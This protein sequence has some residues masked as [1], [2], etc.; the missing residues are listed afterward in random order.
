MVFVSVLMS[1][2]ANTGESSY[3]KQNSTLYFD[4]NLL[5]EES[6]NVARLKNSGTASATTTITAALTN[7][8]ANAAAT[9]GGSTTYTSLV[10]NGMAKF[11]RL[12]QST[13]EKSYIRFESTDTTILSLQANTDSFIYYAWINVMVENTTD[14]TFEIIGTRN[15]SQVGNTDGARLYGIV[16]NE[17]FQL[18]FATINQTYSDTTN[19]NFGQWYFVAVTRESNVI[20]FYKNG[21]NVHTITEFSSSLYTQPSTSTSFAYVGGTQTGSLYIGHFG[22]QNYTTTISVS[23]YYDETKDF[24]VHKFDQ[25]YI[26]DLDFYMDVPRMLSNETKIVSRGSFMT[27]SD[28]L[29]VDPLY[30]RTLTAAIHVDLTNQETLSGLNVLSFLGTASSYLPFI[31]SNE[32][33]NF[34]SRLSRKEVGDF[35]FSIWVKPIRT[36]TETDDNGN[37]KNETIFSNMSSDSSA[38][39]MALCIQ[40]AENKLKLLFSFEG[41]ED[42]YL[43]MLEVTHNDIKSNR[44]FH[45]ACNFEDAGLNSMNNRVHRVKIYING[46]EI[47][48]SYQ[49][50]TQELDNAVNAPFSFGDKA[51]RSKSSIWYFPG[52]LGVFVDGKSTP[53][54]QVFGDFKGYI[55]EFLF[56]NRLLTATEISTILSS[57]LY[58][59]YDPLSITGGQNTITTSVTFPPTLSLYSVK[60]ANNI[61]NDSVLALTD[62]STYYNQKDTNIVGGAVYIFAISDTTNTGKLLR[63]NSTVDSYDATFE[64]TYVTRTGTPGSSGAIIELDLRS[65]TGTEVF[66]FDSATAGMGYVEAPTSGVTTKVVTVALDSAGTAN[67]Y[68]IDTVEKDQIDAVAN[69]TYIFDQSDSSNAGHPIIFGTTADD[70]SN[71]YQPSDGVTIMGTPG[72]PGAYTKLVLPSTFTGSLYY[73]CR[74]HS[75]MGGDF[76]PPAT[77]NFTQTESPPQQTWYNFGGNCRMSRN[78]LYCIVSTS[79]RSSYTSYNVVY[80]YASG[81]WSQKGSVISESSGERS[82]PGDC[83]ISNDGT[84][85]ATSY[86]GSTS[87]T[88]GYVL[89]YEYVNNAWAQKGSTISRSTRYGTYL[90]M[91]DDGNTICATITSGKS[92][93]YVYDYNS[94]TNSWGVRGNASI[95]TSIVTG[96][97][98]ISSDGLRVIGA[99]RNVSNNPTCR[100]ADW[101]ASTSTW[102]NVGSNFSIAN[103]QETSSAVYIGEN[104]DFVTTSSKTTSNDGQVW[105]YNS[106]T[107][108]WNKYGSALA[109]PP[110]NE[111]TAGICHNF[112]PPIINAAGTKVSYLDKQYKYNSSTNTWDVIHTFNYY[113]IGYS[114]TSVALSNTSA[115]SNVQSNGTVQADDANFKI[116]F[117]NFYRV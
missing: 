45:I 6:N 7:T 38:I 20:K 58:T 46:N 81:S 78:G 93:I 17:Q 25:T 82:Y 53:T 68:Y 13:G 8:F 55:G 96:S 59:Y 98:C 79:E 34:A 70:T 107:N 112:F 100:V 50:W 103:T 15:N 74:Y 11:L 51:D 115:C 30:T 52:I 23:D 21:S 29:S 114:D 16:T 47:S 95:P 10:D 40:P 33:F 26:T 57:T 31:K 14:D 48:G 2:L 42:T 18:R 12:G 27:D 73:Y 102:S 99:D 113:I 35:S 37:Y 67:A 62:S 108:T 5:I 49:N 4:P 101:N 22:I 106:S 65:Y 32:K 92:T 94:G 111:Y 91:S 28:N 89:V 104:K 117:Y 97:C 72:Q 43:V 54:D 36:S 60:V 71:F 85:I 87:S 61:Y 19:Y 75:G 110:T 9:G 63:F 1:N 24:Y 76:V 66:Y 3:S 86:G 64:S 80:E 109:A 56:F 41:T 77:W 69:T 105:K 44:W 83:W 88:N 116:D 90:S 84:H 39:G